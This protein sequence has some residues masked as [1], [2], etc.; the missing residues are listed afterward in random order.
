[1]EASRLMGPD[2]R[3]TDIESILVIGSGPIVIGQ[4]C[5]FDYSGT[6]ACRV[7][8]E[9]GYRVILANSNPATIMTDPEFADR[10]YIEPLTPDV[11]AAIIER[12][13]PDALL[14]T[15]GG[16]TGAQPRDGARRAGRRSTEYGVELIGASA[17]AI[18]TAED[19]EPFK[20]AMTRDRPRRARTRASPTTSTRRSRVGDAIGFPIIVRPVVHP[21]RAGHGHRPRP[22]R[23]SSDLAATGL[24][25]EPDHA[26][27]S[28]SASIAGWKEY[29]LEV[30]RDRADNCVV[31]C[32]IENFDPM[33]VHT[34]DSITVAP[35][36]TLSDVE[37]QQMRDAAFACIR[38]VGVETGGSNIQ[39]AVEPR[40]RRAARHRDEPA[41]LAL[42]GARLEGDRAS[43]S[44]RSPPASP[45][46]TRSTRSPTTSPGRRRRASS[47]RS[48]TSSR[49]SRAGPSRSSPARPDRLG[50]R[51]QSVGEVMAIGRTFPESLQKALRG[52]EQGRLGLNGDP[53]EVALRRP[54]A[55]TSC[56]R[57]PRSP[58]PERPFEL[59]AVLRRGV[60]VDDARR[61]DRHRPVVPRPDRRRSSRSAAASRRSPARPAAGSRPSTGG[62]GAAPSASA[63]PTRSSAYLSGATEAEVRA[64]RAR[65]AGCAPP[66]RRSTPAAPSSRPRRRTTTR[67]T[68][69]R[70]RCGPGDRPRVV[71]LGSGPN[72][73]GQGIEFDYCCVHASMALARGRASRRSWSTATPR[74]S[75]PTTTPRTASTSSRSPRRT[76]SHV[77]EAEQAAGAGGVAGVIVGPRRPDPAQARRPAPRPGLVLGTSAAAI[78]LA[79][80]RERWNALCARL[81]I[82]QPRGRRP[83]TTSTRRSRGRRA[84][85]L[86]GARAAE[87]RARRPG[88]GD[89]LRRR[90]PRPGDGASPASTRRRRRARSGARAGSRP[91]ARCSSTASSRTPSRST[92]T[93]SATGRASCSSAGSWSTSRRPACTRA[94]RPASS[95]RRPLG[96]RDHR[97]ARGLHPRDRRGPRG[98]SGPINVQYAVKQ[99]QVFVIEANPRACRTVPFVAKA[100][101]VP[102]AKV[103]ARVM[104]G[105]T[106]AELRAE[107]LL[108]ATPVDG[109]PREREGG[110]PALRPVPRGR[111]PARPG[112]ALDRRGDGHRPRP[113]ASPSPRA[114]SPRA[115]AARPPGTVFLS[116][117][118]RDKAAGVL[119]A[120]RPSPTSASRSRRPPGPPPTS[121]RTA[122]RSPSRVAKLG[123]RT[124]P[125]PTGVRRRRPHRER[126]GPPRREHAAR[127]WPPGRRRPHPPRRLGQPGPDRS[128]PSPRRVPPRRASPTGRAI[129]LQRAAACRSTTRRPVAAHAVTAPAA[130]PQR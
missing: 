94:T 57:R 15:L 28:S 91:S 125:R 45:S 106:L 4:A 8:R 102:L 65:G 87:L 42:V 123:P 63:S 22:R 119:A 120:A 89:R 98:A 100:T 40:H 88:D 68:R 58:T 19:R 6:Q 95:R 41:G 21:R 39:F 35:A 103:A 76:C 128:R 54:A 113:S 130:E 5:E 122:C 38:R 124:G 53:A 72:R 71:I 114:R 60:S 9:E 46:A 31:V 105:A 90:G 3:A 66:S 50:T 115:A 69:T 104:V 62:A 56:S 13:R 47:R 81:E 20:E 11:L 49:R 7:L 96:G 82:P 108:G 33:G 23:V 117:A 79:E 86:P 12:E 29:E 18:R 93:P 30:M 64:A 70:T 16:Q 55:T 111:R 61:G 92:S 14:P 51:M 34:G 44:R 126:R 101:G 67:P 116:L 59:E 97:G 52:L 127:P 10:T 84:H 32:S 24:E 36:Q 121:R 74:R 109:R 78:D 1:M 77:I 83:R 85:R 112:D 43:R 110:G 129:G 80:D 118:D 17:E 73:I 107:G 37:Y 48:T 27:S 2:A 25:R 75:R 99:G 26:R